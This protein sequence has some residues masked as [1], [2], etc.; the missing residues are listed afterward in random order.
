MISSQVS[1]TRTTAPHGFAAAVFALAIGGFAIGTAEFAAMGILPQVATDL[2]ITVPSAGTLISAYALGVVVGAPLITVACANVPRRLLLIVLMVLYALSNGASAVLH[3]YAAIVASRFIAGLP[4]G[5]YF[6]LAALAAASL[7]APNKKGTAI[8]RVMLGLSVANVVGVPLATWLGITFGW[9]ACFAVVAVIAAISATMIRL[10]VPSIPL[11]LKAS[12][13]TELGALRKPVV[14]VTLL[15][16]SVGFG[17]LFCVY[18]YVAGTLTHVTRLPD[19]LVPWALATIGV[20]MLAGSAVIGTFA[21]RWLKG[22]MLGMY[23]STAVVLFLFSWLASNAVA[24]FLLLFCIGVGAAVTI[25]FQSRLMEIAGD[26]QSLAAALNHSAFNIANALG[27]WIGGV[28]ISA[29]LGW[30]STGWV[31]GVLSALGILVLMFS[32]RLG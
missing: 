21:D 18:S 29:G 22:T 25:C 16:G 14:L 6:G 10:T 32:F 31:G 7:V 5:A 11:S 20:G 13:L 19:L 23:A 8:S 1:D 27:A 2:G 28:A 17:G 24:A 9:R 30:A 15:A 26:A 12:P 3:S 4:H